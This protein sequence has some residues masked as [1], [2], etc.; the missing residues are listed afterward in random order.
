MPNSNHDIHV[1]SSPPFER[2]VEYISVCLKNLLR[3]SNL[4]VPPAYRPYKGWVDGLILVVED[5]VIKYAAELPPVLHNVSFATNAG[6]LG[7][8][9]VLWV[10]ED[11]TC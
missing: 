3:S 9:D 8:W 10:A 11:R 6:E 1:V 4:V 5:L 2:V 7:F